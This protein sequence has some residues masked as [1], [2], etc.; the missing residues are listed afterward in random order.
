MEGGAT[1]PKIKQNKSL[2]VVWFFTTPAV[3]GRCREVKKCEKNVGGRRNACHPGPLMHSNGTNKCFPWDEKKI[4]I[5]SQV[6]EEEGE[7]RKLV[8]L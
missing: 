7:Q 2:R 5:F 3:R 4:E 6:T 8:K 1:S